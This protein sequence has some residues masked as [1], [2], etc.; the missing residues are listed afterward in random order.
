MH[1]GRHFAARDVRMAFDD[2]VV[3]LPLAAGSTLEDIALLWQDIVVTR[4]DNPIDIKITFVPLIAC[5]ATTPRP[6]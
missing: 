4:H 6:S 2:T 3:S 5:G 1:Q